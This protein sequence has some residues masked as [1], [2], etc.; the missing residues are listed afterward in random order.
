MSRQFICFTS[1][2]FIISWY[3]LSQCFEAGKQFPKL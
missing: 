3:F 2:E 1:I